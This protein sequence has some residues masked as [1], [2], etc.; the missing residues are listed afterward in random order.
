MPRFEERSAIFFR[1][2]TKRNICLA[3]PPIDNIDHKMEREEVFYFRASKRCVLVGEEHA[4]FL[5]L[6]KSILQVARHFITCI[7]TV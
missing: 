3:L 5:G 6:V 2:V 4:T 1:H 7:I